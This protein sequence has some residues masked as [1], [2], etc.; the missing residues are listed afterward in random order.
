MMREPNPHAAIRARANTLNR[1]ARVL[2]GEQEGIGRAVKKVVLD[3]RGRACTDG[4]TVWVPLVMDEDAKMN[5]LMQEAVLA[6]E[7][8]GHLRYT[9]FSAWEKVGDKIKEGEEDPILHTFTNIIEDARVNHL[10]AQD[11]PGSGRRLDATQDYYMAK[12]RE[13]W[14][15]SGVTDEN[16]RQAALV[17]MM[18]EAIAHQPHFFTEDEALCAFMDEVRDE[19]VRAMTRRNTNEAIKSARR[20]LA[21]FRIHFP[22]DAAEDSELFGMP[23]SA[24]ADGLTMDDMSPEEIER[25]A[26]EQRKASTASPTD[27]P[28]SRFKD[29]KEKMDEV[30]EAAQKAAE[31]AKKSSEGQDTT[32]GNDDAQDA[33]EGG[34]AGDG[35]GTDGEGTDGDEGE[36]QTGSGDADGEG[37][38][39]MTLTD[40]EGE[41]EG[42]GTMM[43]APTS[44]D[45]IGEGES[46]ETMSSDEGGWGRSAVC[47]EELFAEME[48]EMDAEN[49]EALRIE[50]RDN[51]DRN[52][53]MA[54][55]IEGMHFPAGEQV[56][57]THSTEEMLRRGEVVVDDAAASYDRIKADHATQVT[58]LVNQMRR[59]LTSENRPE[60]GQKRGR[61]D[62]RRLWVSQTSDRLF[63]RRNDT[64][65]ADV[66]ALIL[67]DASGSMSGPRSKRASEA[68]VVLTE[69]M[70]RIGWAVEVV[71]FNSGWKDTAIR[72]RKAMTAPV[73]RYTKAAIA[74]PFVGSSNGDGYAVQWSL[75]RL[76]AFK[77]HRLLFVIS[78][79]QPA[80]PSPN[81]M[82]EEEHLI[83]VVQNAPR[84]IGLFSIGIDGMDTSAYYPHSASCNA[85][86]LAQAVLP[87]LRTMVRRIKRA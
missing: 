51:A 81:G 54:E 73:N 61:L 25:M 43:V 72:V 39:S 3:P 41:G 16:R 77:G 75:D 44:S 24:E 56:T 36:G 17:A 10:L 65:D 37:E 86:G 82:T 22:E 27:A 59:L 67:I 87:V 4:S 7:A 18:T 35:E 66:N 64:G 23:Q 76:S 14:A 52:A 42:H 48:S 79:G 28:S 12:H 58:T 19:M 53:A 80:G 85:D 63:T 9:N 62:T 55:A 6:H 74:T 1:L 46:H 20:V 57:V 33:S 49:L 50:D 70:S 26:K 8:A 2:S 21:V 5:R 78:D 71:D 29:L 84:D 11:F 47:L 68:A 40:G 69:A 30:K 34:S 38:G 31:A 13:M 45:E 60:Q 15:E 32:D 83:S